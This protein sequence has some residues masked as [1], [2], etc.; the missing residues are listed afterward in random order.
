LGGKLYS[1]SMSD[2][3]LAEAVAV[4]LGVLTVV[5]G[6]FII[7]IKQAYL[8]GVYASPITPY[9]S[10]KGYVSGFSQPLPVP[11]EMEIRRVAA[12]A[13][14]DNLM[15]VKLQVWLISITSLFVTAYPLVSRL[16]NSIIPATSISGVPPVSMVWAGLIPVVLA[17]LGFSLVL[18][19]M[20]VTAYEAYFGVS[21]TRSFILVL[22]DLSLYIIGVA[23]LFYGLYMMTG[24]PEVGILFGFLGA[25][26]VDRVPL[27]A[28]GLLGFGLAVDLTGILLLALASYRRWLAL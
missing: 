23:I 28:T 17:S 4:L 15:G 25:L 27:S 10:I 3:S 12:R 21:L 8:A 1:L 13:F 22:L 11:S 7:L 2:P 5:A 20:G 16:R 6:F 19:G 18:V 9:G 26:G 24:R 14:T